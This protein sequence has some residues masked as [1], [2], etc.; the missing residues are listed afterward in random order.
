MVLSERVSR[1][2]KVRHSTQSTVDS[3]AEQM[4]LRTCGNQGIRR[5]EVSILATRRELHRVPVYVQT[6]TGANIWG[7]HLSL[8]KNITQRTEPHKAGIASVPIR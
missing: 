2:A 7:I 6:L 8:E 3:W 4:E 5:S 1:R